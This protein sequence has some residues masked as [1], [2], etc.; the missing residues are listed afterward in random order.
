MLVNSRGTLLG[1][2]MFRTFGVFVMC[3]L[4]RCIQMKPFHIMSVF[5]ICFNELSTLL[6][7]LILVFVSSSSMLETLLDTGCNIIG[8]HFYQRIRGTV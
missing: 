4:A 6:N 5:N 7:A 2:G 3:S 1:R 8:D